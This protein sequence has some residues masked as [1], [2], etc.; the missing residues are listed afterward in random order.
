MQQR[1]SDL[2][3]V[4]AHS[5][6][7]T[8]MRT[9]PLALLACSGA[10]WVV[11]RSVRS[12]WVNHGAA[13]TAAAGLL[14]YAGWRSFRFVRKRKSSELLDRLEPLL[15]FSGGCSSARICEDS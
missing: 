15:T 8:F 7:P 13:K 9:L 2:Q 1:L 4:P 5:N 14:A 10:V 12:H 6:V 3:L 11:M